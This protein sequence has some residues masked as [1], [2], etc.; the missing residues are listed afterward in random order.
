MGV[1]LSTASPSRSSSFNRYQFSDYASSDSRTVTT[2][3]AGESS[4]LEIHTRR[5]LNIFTLG[6]LKSATQNFKPNNLLGEGGFGR[7]YKGW[8]DEMTLSPAKPGSGMV[9]AVKKLD[10]EGLQGHAEW[11]SEVNFLGRLSHPNLIKLLGYCI[12][13]TELLIVYEFM[14]KG[15]LHNHLFRRIPNFEPLSWNT[16]LQIAIGAARG[17]T[18]LHASEPPVIHR[19]LKTSNILLDGN[20]NAKISDF[21]LAKLGPS[22]V[23][24][25]VTTRVMGTL[26]YAAPEYVATGHLYVK[27][28]VYVFGVVLLEILTGM[29]ALDRNRPAM[30]QN[31][32]EWT[33]PYLSSKKMLKTIMDAKIKSQYSLKA[34]WQT[35]QLVLKCLESVPG[36]RPSMQEVLEG[37]EAIETIP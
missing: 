34:A 37:L 36:R 28:D 16:R 6:E 18:F 31:L 15:S 33:K 5:E 26:G 29:K 11:Q 32:V 23:E 9:V 8:L 30:Q 13:D 12:E 22:D 3:S 4:F 2:S 21:G 24:S 7:V 19:G 1:P 25:H 14:P 17:L 27:S 10:P 20:Y 35:A